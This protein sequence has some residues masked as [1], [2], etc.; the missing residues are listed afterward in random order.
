M[1]TPRLDI[2]PASQRR[3]W[4]ELDATP[5]AFA[6]Y[7]GTALA[8]R[9]G[10]RESV[11]FDFFAFSDFDPSKLRASVP[12]LTGGVPLQEERNT[13]T[14]LLDRGG[15]IQMSF[16]GV[17]R[18]GQVEPHD[19]V[20]DVGIR[21][22]SLLDL[23]GMKASVVY[24]RAEPKDYLDIHALLTSAKIPLSMM[25][26]AGRAIYGDEFNP[27]IALKAISYHDDETLRA[28]PEGVRRDLVAAV[29]AVDVDA[30]PTLTPIRPRG[31]RA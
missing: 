8:L 6:L 12:Y 3:L 4:G 25:L 15:P 22:A 29:R 11:D 14:M 10:H 18:L 31:G 9:L 27:M 21:I 5:P 19:I 24:R 26:S 1:F 23:A 30:L 16:F 28:L 17:P 7:D 13:L 20:E 2:L